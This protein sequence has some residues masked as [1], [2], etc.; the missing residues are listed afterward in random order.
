MPLLPCSTCIMDQSKCKGFRSITQ[1]WAVRKLNECI[2]S[3][4]LSITKTSSRMN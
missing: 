4:S 1:D 3:W 2:T